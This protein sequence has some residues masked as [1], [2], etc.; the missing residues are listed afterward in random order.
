MDTAN[1]TEEPFREHAR[2]HDDVGRLYWC[3]SVRHL[4]LCSQ[5]RR[6]SVVPQSQVSD[7]A[8]KM[9]YRPNGLGAR[10]ERAQ[11]RPSGPPTLDWILET[12]HEFGRR[13]L[14][15]PALGSFHTPT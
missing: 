2:H 3:S 4:E 14:V 10:Q 12:A 11:S 7:G 8:K 9:L 1:H 15:L 13:A 6:K 5:R